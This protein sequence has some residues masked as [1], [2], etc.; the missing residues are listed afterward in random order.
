ME[1]KKKDTVF[2]KCTPIIDNRG[3]IHN[4]V[5]EL[6]PLP[7]MADYCESMRKAGVIYT[8]ERYENR[9]ESN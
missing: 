6:V 7:E 1:K 9:E 2:Y 3:E 8:M 4:P 5:T